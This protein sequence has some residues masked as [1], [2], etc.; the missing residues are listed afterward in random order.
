MSD[1]FDDSLV[2]LK[3]TERG[4]CFIEYIPAENA[5]NPILADEYMYIDFTAV[6]EDGLVLLKNYNSP[7][8]IHTDIRVFINGFEIPCCS[9][10]DQIL[11]KADD[12]KGYGFDV[13]WYENNRTLKISRNDEYYDVNPVQIPP[14]GIS[15]DYYAPAIHTDISIKRVAL[16]T[17]SKTLKS[18]CINNEMFIRPEDLTTK[19][20]SYEYNNDDRALYIC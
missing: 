16:A 6:K 20:I 7:F 12:L 10:N 18:Y 11:I 4:K 2:F 14:K 19:G 17:A 3:S 9:F 15:G 13:I 5:W 8:A 1:R